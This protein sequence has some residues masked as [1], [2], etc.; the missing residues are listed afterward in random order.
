MLSGDLAANDEVGAAVD[1]VFQQEG[2]VAVPHFAQRGA[3][4]FGHVVHRIDAHQMR[5]GV[6]PD[7]LFEMVD[8]GLGDRKI[9]GIDHHQRPVAG[10]LESLHF[11]K[12]GNVVHP[13]VSARIR[14][15]DDTCIDHGRNAISHG[16]FP[17]G[18]IRPSIG[19]RKPS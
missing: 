2:A 9:A 19:R 11:A 4:Q 18:F 16:C 10:A 5:L 3:D 12:G 1:I 7:G 17:S 14:C 13:G 15:K 8:G 6:A